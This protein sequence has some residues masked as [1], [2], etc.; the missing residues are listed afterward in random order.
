ME[1]WREHVLF[2]VGDDAGAAHRLLQ[3]I[4]GT[5]QRGR[6][7]AAMMGRQAREAPELPPLCLLLPL[8]IPDG[9]E[10]APVT[11]GCCVASCKYRVN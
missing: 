11:A 7:E 9:V 6:G 5:K 10:A 3:E 2:C 8:E 1:R 4:A